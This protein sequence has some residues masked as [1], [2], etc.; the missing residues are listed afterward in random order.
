MHFVSQAFGR[1]QESLLWQLQLLIPV[2]ELFDYADQ[3]KS[4]YYH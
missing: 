2:L 1:G 3:C 4:V